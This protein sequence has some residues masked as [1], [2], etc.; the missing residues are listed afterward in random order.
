[1]KREALTLKLSS[2]LS[3]DKASSSAGKGALIHPEV[4]VVVFLGQWWG[5]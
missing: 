3:T 1:M 4:L 2:P 5:I